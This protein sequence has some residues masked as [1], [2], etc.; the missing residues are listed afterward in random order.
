M[1]SLSNFFSGRNFFPLFLACLLACLHAKVIQKKKKRKKKYISGGAGLA[2]F[3]YQH[4][5]SYDHDHDAFNFTCGPH[6]TSPHLTFP[7]AE[8]ESEENRTRNCW[9][10]VG[11]LVQVPELLVYFVPYSSPCCHTLLGGVD[12]VCNGGGWDGLGW[13]SLIF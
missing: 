7:P 13:R 8:P 2:S 11:T 9:M 12:T 6:F 3:W 10:T 1:V 4:Q 5:H